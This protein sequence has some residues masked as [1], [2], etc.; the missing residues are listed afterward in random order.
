MS[1]LVNSLRAQTN[2]APD[3]VTE[4]NMHDAITAVQDETRENL[5][6][7]REA[8]D[9]QIARMKVELS[10]IP[11]GQTDR[12]NA[13]DVAIK[14]LETLKTM[15]EHRQTVTAPGDFE[16][17]GQRVGSVAQVTASATD[18]AT[19]WLAG[20]PVLG[21]LLVGTGIVSWTRRVW[22]WFSGNT[23]EDAGKKKKKKKAEAPE[24]E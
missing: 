13:Y 17:V 2:I 23:E 19:K 12:R 20:V 5:T 3:R 9:V 4:P 14:R 16:R 21:A 10:G 7:M 11:T 15:I 6:K 24:T 18:T 22:G 1:E 8:I